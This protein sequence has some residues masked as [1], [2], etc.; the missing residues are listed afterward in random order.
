MFRCFILTGYSASGDVQTGH[1]TAQ[2]GPAGRSAAGQWS[3]STA[4]LGWVGTLINKGWL[5]RQHGAHPGERSRRS[6]GVRRWAWPE[7]G[8]RVGRLSL[9][10]F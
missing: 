5:D 10:G 9:R 6:G 7:P 8:S 3:G 4:M 2:V 1:L